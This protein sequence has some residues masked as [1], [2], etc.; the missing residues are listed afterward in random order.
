M[1]RSAPAWNRGTGRGWVGVRFTGFVG[2]GR[3]RQEVGC[4]RVQPKA[5][6]NISEEWEE[7][8]GG[9]A[10]ASTYRVEVWRGVL[11]PINV[12][13]IISSATN[14]HLKIS[15]HHVAAETWL[16]PYLEF[17]VVGEGRAELPQSRETHVRVSH[18]SG[19][20]LVDVGRTWRDDREAV[21]PSQS[22]R[23]AKVS[24][25]GQ[26]RGHPKM[27]ASSTGRGMPRA[28]RTDTRTRQKARA[29]SGKCPLRSNGA[30]EREEGER[31]GARQER[32]ERWRRT[33]AGC[34][35]GCAFCR[36]CWRQ[37]RRSGSQNVC[38]INV[39]VRE[40]RVLPERLCSLRLAKLGRM[41]HGFSICGG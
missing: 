19:P 37:N 6:L 14:N 21:R 31:L 12:L 17:S 26:R 18:Q 38:Y 5:I 28:V 33:T 25:H 4:E 15:Q 23:L 7:G 3:G 30:G 20:V 39:I 22:G 10:L 11:M 27:L 34:R 36:Y 40:S 13:H 41:H 29:F 1:F 8:R 24:G 32:G 9:R 2:R 35:G 16:T